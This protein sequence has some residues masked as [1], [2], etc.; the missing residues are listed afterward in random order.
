MF[1]KPEND[2]KKCY[3]HFEFGHTHFWLLMLASMDLRYTP[4]MTMYFAVSVSRWRVY[5]YVDGAVGRLLYT[6]VQL[7][8]YT[9]R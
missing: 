4:L 3:L 6:V 5:V 7:P 1:E 2:D 8:H 9:S